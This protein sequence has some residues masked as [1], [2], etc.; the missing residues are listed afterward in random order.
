MYSVVLMAALATSTTSPAF[1]RGGWIGGCHGCYACNG[2]YCNG[3][4]GYPAYGC[5]GVPVVNSCHGW[6]AY[7]VYGYG[8]AGGCYGYHGGCYGAF[9]VTFADPH[10]GF[11][12]G[13]YGCYGGYAGYGVP[14]PPPEGIKPP[15]KEKEKDMFPPINPKKDKDKDAEEIPPLKEKKKDKEPEK[16]VRAKVRIEVPEGGKLFVDGNRIDVGAGTRVF[17]TPPL[18]PGRTYYYD[19]RIEV[20]YNGVTRHEERRVYVQ[21]G[22]DALVHFPNLRPPNSVAQTNR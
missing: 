9:G 5:Y 12:T 18:A 7:P 21:P 15:T 4:Y 14:L 19:V 20:A 8:V 13:C 3:C 6:S 22:Q 17:Q 2:C 16:S 11:P 10:H 1:F